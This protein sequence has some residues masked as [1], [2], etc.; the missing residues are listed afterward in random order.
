MLQN[1]GNVEVCENE[2]KDNNSK[3]IELN[4]KNLEIPC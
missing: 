4:E 1:C 3:K 2:S